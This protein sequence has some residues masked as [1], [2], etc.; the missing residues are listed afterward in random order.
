MTDP[1]DNPEVL[2]GPLTVVQKPEF[3]LKAL[4][5]EFPGHQSD[6]SIPEAF[7]CLVLSA[8]FADGRVAEQEQE[9]LRALARR[10]R[11]LKSLDPN[12]LAE[13]NRTVVRR[14]ADR[15]GWLAE[16]AGA[17]PRDMR[18]SVFAHCLDITLADGVLVT[19]EADY[20]EE[21]VTHLEL[22]RDDAEAIIRVLSMKNRY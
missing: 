14:R 3:S 20:L 11:I 15:P 5:S 22:R 9:E 6:W 1:A 7:L 19:A 17:L 2:F 4:I 8:A 21:L 12:E 10:S 18:L 16:A 13:V